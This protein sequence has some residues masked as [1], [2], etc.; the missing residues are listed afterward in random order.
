MAHNSLYKTIQRLALPALM[1]SGLLFSACNAKDEP[2][3]SDDYLASESV[4]V[5]AFSLSADLRVMRNLDSVFF[6]IDLEHGV[7]F[8]A[9]SLP[10]GTNVTKLIPKISYP[11]SVTSASI[12]M[13]GGTHR[14]GTVK[15]Y[16][17]STDTIDFTGDVTLTLATSNN[18]IEKTYTLKVNVHQ[19]DPDTV[20]WSNTASSDLPSALPSPID[21]KSVEWGE[22]AASFIEENN[23]SYTLATTTDLFEGNWNKTS[24]NL[25]FTPVVSSFTIG[26]GGEFFLLDDNGNLYSSPEGEIWTAV[27]SGWQNIIGLYNGTLI[28]SSEGDAN[29]RMKS[30]P[31][32]DFSS[33]VLPAD[34][35][36]GGYTTPIEFN[37]RW[38]SEPT[39]IIFGGY[40]Y[41]GQNASPSWAFDGQEW[42]NIADSALPPLSGLSVVKYYSF[43][44]SASSSHLREFEVYLAF[45]GKRPDGSINNTVYI[46]Y[47]YGIN[48]QKAQEYVQL[49]EDMQAGYMVNAISRGTSMQSNLSDRW[50]KSSLKRKIPYEI[51]GDI[52]SWECPYIFLFGGFDSN[53]KLNDKIRSGVLQR[54]TFVPLF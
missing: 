16:A 25:D 29:R 50:E 32:T 18:A 1:L 15:Y 33:I 10:K 2:S 49:P 35:P 37:N 11:S 31:T 38:T 17:S 43:L 13:T 19:Q 7:I 8:N 53:F 42:A 9:D 52:I 27:D 47:D 44:K 5:T 45:G 20:Y 51:N 30:W 22:G 26:A 40:P 21:Q 4:A 48:W 34:F 28:G 23:G 54:L 24:L 6:S 12:T 46:S 14:E 36:T 3:K 39:I 41:T